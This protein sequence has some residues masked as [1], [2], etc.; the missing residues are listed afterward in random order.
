MQSVQRCGLQLRLWATGLFIPVEK[1]PKSSQK[2]SGC[3]ATS[4]PSYTDNHK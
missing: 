4:F 3:S 1:Y 2:E